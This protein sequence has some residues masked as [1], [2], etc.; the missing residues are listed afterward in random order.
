[1]TRPARQ[2]TSGAR[3]STHGTSTTESSTAPTS[4]DETGD[5]PLHGAA[6]D[7]DLHQTPPVLWVSVALM[8]LGV[9]LV[10]AAVV[11]MSKSTTIAVALLAAGAVVAAVGAAVGVRNHIMTNVE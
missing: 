10:G 7:K 11:A 1:M 8:C 9:A 2:G 4:A 6:F 5:S 3:T